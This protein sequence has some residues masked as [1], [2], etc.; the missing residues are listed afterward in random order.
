MSAVFCRLAA[1][2]DDVEALTIGQ[3]ESAILRVFLAWIDY[4]RGAAKFQRAA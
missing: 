2:D 1:I 3:F 4:R